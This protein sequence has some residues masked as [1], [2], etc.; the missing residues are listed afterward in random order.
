MLKGEY[1]ASLEKNGGSNNPHRVKTLAAGWRRIDEWLN[2]SMKIVQIL[3]Q[4]RFQSNTFNSRLFPKS[5]Q[6]RIRTMVRKVVEFLCDPVLETFAEW[7]W[8]EMARWRWFLCFRRVQPHCQKHK[9][10]F[11]YYVTLFLADFDPP[12][13]PLSQS[14]TPARTPPPPPVT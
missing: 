1:I 14:V 13:P 11:N 5:D 12:P 7:Q 8:Y 6:S 9:G 2:Q 10:P 4:Q 3:P